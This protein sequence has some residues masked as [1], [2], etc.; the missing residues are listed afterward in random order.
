M[1]AA[2]NDVKPPLADTS[3]ILHNLLKNS[4]IEP[5]TTIGNRIRPTLSR[6]ARDKEPLQLFVQV[7]RLVFDARFAGLVPAFSNKI[8]SPIIAQSITIERSNGK[9]LAKNSRS[10]REGSSIRQ[11]PKKRLRMPG[12]PIQALF[13]SNRTTVVAAFGTQARSGNASCKNLGLN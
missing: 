9:P 8:I 6:Y 13:K 1:V 11:L 4:L 7:C 10:G 12:T 3:A 2:C 5:E